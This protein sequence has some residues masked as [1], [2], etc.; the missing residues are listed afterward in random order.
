MRKII[1]A[2]VFLLAGAANAFGQST[3]VSGNVTDLGSQAWAGGTYK[4]MFTPNPQFP[5]GPYTWTGGTLNL[6]ISGSL[7]GSG[8]YSVSIPS[9]TAISPQGSTWILQV[10]PNAT[11]ASFSSPKTTIT[12]ATQTLNV[13]PPAVTT[14]PTLFARAYADSEITGATIGSQY[15]N[16]TTSLVRVCTAVTGLVCTTWANVGTG[17]GGGVTGS[18]VANQV[19]FWTAAS[20]IGGNANLTFDPVADSFTAQG[21]TGQVFLAEGAANNNFL[22]IT[23]TQASIQ[24][25]VS[26][27]TAGV[28]ADA[29]VSITSDTGNIAESAVNGSITLNS[30]TTGLGDQ[31]TFF[32]TYTAGAT[33]TS[34]QLLKFNGTGE[35]VI[36]TVTSDTSGIIGVAISAATN[37]NP[38]LVNRAWNSIAL[39]DN[40][41]SCADQ[42]PIINSTTTAG[43]GH[44]TATP[45]TSQVVGGFLSTG[46]G[47]DNI[48]VYPFAGGLASGVQ[49]S[50]SGC[51]LGG[52]SD[53]SVAGTSDTILAADR[54][55]R[56]VYTSATAV[57]VTLPQAGTAGFANSFYYIT[58]NGGAGAVT[59]TPT[60][61]T[62]NGN[63]TLVLNEGDACRIG[64][65]S[66]G[67]SYAADCAPPQLVAGTGITLTP[68]VHS[69]TIASTG[70]TPSFP[71]T[72]A[73]TVTSGGIPYF[74]STT[75]ESSSAILNT[76]ILVKGGGAGGA[77]TNSSITDNGTTVSTSEVVT[78]SGAGAASTS[79]VLINGT[80]F[81]SGGSA[82][83][84]FP[85]VYLNAPGAAAP[86]V[87]AT[88]GTMFGINA[89][90]GIGNIVNFLVNGVSQFNI[91]PSGTISSAGAFNGST[92]IAAASTATIGFSTRGKM[93]SPADSIL[94]L[95]NN[96]A[97]AFN[98]LDFGGTTS[99]FPA[100]QV[101]G[102]NLQAELA[103][104]S[105]LT[106]LSASNLT[107]NT[108]STGTNCSS[109]AS[110]AVCAAAAGGSV[111]IAAAATTLVVNTTAVTANSQILLTVDSSLGTKLGVTCDTQSS[112]VIGSPSV[113]ARTAATSFTITIPVGTTTNPLCLSYLVL[114]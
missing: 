99:S 67:T 10:T 72:V 29:A 79:S 17:A 101:S 48:D 21:T 47:S 78:L 53:R 38:V 113:S 109:S 83:T 19:A 20:V 45:G 50:F 39:L 96:A 105:G 91:G 31:G 68:A 61:S 57:A 16:V 97:S 12:G 51:A 44:C 107:S 114:N 27:S 110:P 76:N 46:G 111:A 104:G 36:P 65:N 13:T 41:G 43:D 34:G 18:G 14:P 80:P 81:T 7:D 3:T 37:G 62:I 82:T 40:S 2:F 86:T 98:R 55:N 63:A 66:T 59:I 70:G 75:Q 74:N 94:L 89:P 84:T 100:L 6:V 60:V 92:A 24:A 93:S 64:P 8:N 35:N 49:P 28:I 58:S 4:F 77:P 1:L 108:Y 32:I 69:L 71:V 90:T 88:A 54:C 42:E 52:Q 95:Q 106:G 33:I 56:V 22:I 23:P 103:D 15:F 25:L 73:G 11:S 26:G 87:F 85:L 5:T 30:L 102:A 9:N 112:L